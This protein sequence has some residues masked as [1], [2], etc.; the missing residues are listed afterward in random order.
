MNSIGHDILQTN[1]ENIVP[2]DEVNQIKPKTSIKPINQLKTLEY[3]TMTLIT[4]ILNHTHT[5]KDIIK[6]IPDTNI[7][8]KH[9][10]TKIKTSAL[11]SSLSCRSNSG[12]CK[13]SLDSLKNPDNHSNW[14]MNDTRNYCNTTCKSYW[15]LGGK[16]QMVVWT[17][18]SRGKGTR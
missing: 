7:Q 13:S 2:T 14:P 4:D 15:V 6:L 11:N 16:S 1:W 5:Y 10:R 3:T 18:K 8:I 9:T 17:V 12:V